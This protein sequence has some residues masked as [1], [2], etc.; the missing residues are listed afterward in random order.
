MTDSFKQ[1][2]K[3]ALVAAIIKSLVA[4][5]FTALFVVGVVMLS[6]KLSDNYLAWY[7]YLLIGVGAMILSYAG[8]FFITYP[9]DKALAKRL[10]GDYK[11]NEKVQTMVEFFD[12]RGELIDLQRSNADEVL[13]SLPP[14][15]FSFKRIWQYI[16]VA[17]VGIT[18]FLAG[19]LVP[20]EYV[21]P[22]TP[23]KFEMSDWDKKN[24]AQLIED[25]RG[26]ELNAD[27]KTL[28][29]A[30]LEQLRADLETTETN[31]EMRSKVTAAA[32]I[33]DDAVKQFNSY[34]NI[35]LALDGNSNLNLFKN[36]IISAA[37]SYKT[38]S[39]IISI[40]EVVLRQ[41]VSEGKIREALETFTVAFEGNFDSTDYSKMLE[42]L[43]TFLNNFNESMIS[44]DLASVTD[45]PL[46]LALSDYSSAIGDD[47]FCSGFNSLTPSYIREYISAADGRYVT[48]VASPIVEQVYARMVDELILN[49]LSEIFGLN[50]SPDELVLSGG[51]GEGDSDSPDDPSHDGGMGEEGV[52]PGGNGIVYNHETNQQEQ[53]NNMWSSSYYSKLFNY[54]NTE[55]DISEELKS[56]IL[57]YMKKLDGDSTTEE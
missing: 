29:V 38:G 4:G 18:L 21:P 44:D 7:F 6:V 52:I 55:A 50:L 16:V 27:L 3:K 10:D 51:S 14:R 53:Y 36:S 2:K 11:L 42:A 24:L 49:K 32:D 57:E 20:S 28:S 15:K 19:V 30:A 31:S 5:L 22:V 54:I 56:Y 40:E 39:K 1:L 47:D 25:V 46:Y 43:E 8:A 37:D 48:A 41:A 34:R 13:K 9:R 23:D 33:I 45:D 35:V 26:S 17:I 12:Q